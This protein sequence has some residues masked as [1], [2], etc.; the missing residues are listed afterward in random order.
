MSQRRIITVHHRQSAREP[1][2]TWSACPKK[3]ISKW[4]WSMRLM[5]T[6]PV[7]NRISL[8]KIKSYNPL[9]L[10]KR[11]LLHFRGIQASWRVFE[12]S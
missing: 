4:E 11:L 8:N 9:A 6:R 1:T 10:K 5:P 7:K 12:A 3:L 2:L